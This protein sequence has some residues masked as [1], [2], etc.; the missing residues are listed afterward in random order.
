MRTRWLVAML[1]LPIIVGLVVWPTKRPAVEK[2]AHRAELIM[3]SAATPIIGPPVIRSGGRTHSCKSTCDD[4][5]CGSAKST[6]IG[7]GG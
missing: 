2:L 7:S 1:A 6:G 4:S 3:R 5:V